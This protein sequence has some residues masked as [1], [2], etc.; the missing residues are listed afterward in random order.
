MSESLEILG[1]KFYDLLLDPDQIVMR[2]AIL[3]PDN[4]IIFCNCKAGTGKTTLS[5]ACA[6]FLYQHKKYDGIVYIAAPVQESKIGFL[7]GSVEEKSAPYFDAF[8]DA[9]EEIDINPNTAIINPN[10]LL[11][12]KNGTAYIQCTTHTFLR[13]MNFSKKVIIIDE[14]QNMY[15]DEL[16]KVLTRVHD[17]C[18]VIVIG[19]SGQCDLYK[20]PQNSGFVKYIDHFRGYPRVAVCTLSTNHRGW[21]STH[22]DD[23]IV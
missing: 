20:N 10:N 15:T 16:K 7:P 2:D 19:H 18:K 13:G 1:D 14:S 4:L 12:Q 5:A 3:D 21:I 6:D 9:L 17:D 11:S 8:I 22:A 23:L